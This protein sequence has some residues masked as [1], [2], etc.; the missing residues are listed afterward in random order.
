MRVPFFMIKKIYATIACRV[1]SDGSTI[2][3]AYDDGWKPVFQTQSDG[4]LTI[5]FEKEITVDRGTG[6]EI[7]G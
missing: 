3:K 7:K 6:E 5:T 4:V 1:T 2:K